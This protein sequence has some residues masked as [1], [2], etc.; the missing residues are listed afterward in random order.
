MTIT[1]WYDRKANRINHHNHRRLY[2]KSHPTWNHYLPHSLNDHAM[3]TTVTSISPKQQR[4]QTKHKNAVSIKIFGFIL[5]EKFENYR[6]KFVTLGGASYC[7]GYV[8]R[9]D[10]KY[11]CMVSICEITRELMSAEKT[12]FPARL[13]F[14]DAKEL[15]LRHA[16][17]SV[18]R[19]PSWLIKVSTGRYKIT[20]NT[21]TPREWMC[22]EATLSILLVHIDRVFAASQEYQ[23]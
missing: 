18:L 22:A 5:H 14:A 21:V 3:V 9:R 4:V 8:N 11:N 7:S 15:R 12:F 6:K 16:V 2:Q 1:S 10:N 13:Q 20:C 19:W 17:L 23:V